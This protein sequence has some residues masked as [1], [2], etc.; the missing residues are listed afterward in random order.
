MAPRER[1]ELIPR[2]LGQWWAKRALSQMMRW[3]QLS[4]PARVRKN[5]RSMRLR[6]PAVRKNPEP[7]EPL[8]RRPGYVA[9]GRLAERGGTLKKLIPSVFC[10]LGIMLAMSGCE[11]EPR[12]DREVLDQDTGGRVVF[13]T[14]ECVT[15][16]ADG[17]RCDKKTCKKDAESNCAYFAERCLATGH[18]YSGT[19]DE[20]TC[21][22]K[23]TN[24]TT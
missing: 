17:V 19:T 16:N 13:A 3:R 2:S 18:E 20:G 14:T 15:P 6:T 1:D 5:E 4:H 24:H 10:A 7:W 22:R 12:A 21:T 8:G 11:T 23:P 9:A